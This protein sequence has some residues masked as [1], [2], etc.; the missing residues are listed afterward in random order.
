MVAHDL[1]LL[2]DLRSNIPIQRVQG[3]EAG[4]ESVDVSQRERFSAE[5][6]NASENICHPSARLYILAA[7][8]RKP[9]P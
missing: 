2:A 8:E 6:P 1:Q 7:K 9:L 4:F 3:G 5:L